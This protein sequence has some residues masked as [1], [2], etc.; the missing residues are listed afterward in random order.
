[1]SAT[2][3]AAAAPAWLAA[4]A[5]DW[6][7]L[8]AAMTAE[9]PAIAGRPVPVA[10]A[11]AAGLGH[12]ACYL[13]DIPVIEV[14]GDSLGTSPAGCDPA[15]PADRERY[16]VTWGA[17][18]HEC[19]H[20]AHT[21]DTLPG[22]RRANWCTAANELEESRI[23]A[24]QISRRPGDRRWLRAA[25]TKIILDDF[26]SG[27][28]APGTPREAGRAAALLLARE[29]AGILE[30]GETTTVAATVE[31]IIGP[32]ALARL[33]ATWR[34][35]HRTADGDIKAMTRLARRWCRILG[36]DPDAAPPAPLTIAVSDLLDA[37]RDAI[38][39]I[40]ATV[41][42]DFAPPLP[43][44]PGAAEKR[45]HEKAVRGRADR[46]AREVFGRRG[47]PR[48]VT[49]TR[50]PHQEEIAA[51]RRLAR[52]LREATAGQRATTTVTSKVPPGRL[53]M[54]KALAIQAQRAA[55][56]VPTAEPFTR[57]ISR[58]VPAPPLRVG[59][60]CDISGSMGAFTGPVASAA[61]IL[62]RA[63]S[64]LPVAQTATVLFGEAV[65]AL[66]R[67]GGTPAQVSDFDATDGTE[68]ACHAIDALDGALALSKP[69]TA[70]LLVIVSDAEFVGYGEPAGVQ[71][72]ITRLH[73]AGC[74][75]IILAPHGQARHITFTDCQITET[76][77]P[78]D[79]IDAIARA[80]TRALTA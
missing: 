67:P 80:A 62:A 15:S 46:A 6:K 32:D 11:P 21:S 2:A 47:R 12:P 29:D 74:G 3:T 24:R 37:I 70:R 41:E 14:D 13:P 7:T 63:A 44:P 66:T 78:A 4:P 52:T 71:Q 35:V 73:R 60:A 18:I 17:L 64:H 26:T 8:S 25:A 16:P 39:E 19:A 68:S 54:G 9:V 20:A 58:R 42:A 30:P 61:W 31:A 5:G 40:E 76:A 38:K 1:M 22:P 72:R 27:G 23:E 50:D 33:G 79:A 51:A 65:H 77:D 34:E 59:I 53:R 55:G 49:G 28:A 48:A 56:A 75:V 57:T 43:F 45:E 36:I 10:C 69:G